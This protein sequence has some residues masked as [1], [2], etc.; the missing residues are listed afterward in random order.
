VPI[1]QSSLRDEL[2]LS[3]RDEDGRAWRPVP[4]Y[5]SIVDNPVVLL[6]TLDARLE[7]ETAS[8]K[9]SLSCRASLPVPLKLDLDSP[10]VVTIGSRWNMTASGAII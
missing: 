5:A 3:R 6:Y 10:A 1:L 2:I 9:E 7:L 4:R 8:T